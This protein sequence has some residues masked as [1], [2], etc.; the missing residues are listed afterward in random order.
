M[1]LMTSPTRYGSIARALHWS[2]AVLFLA[3][4]LAGDGAG[5]A[6][7]HGA[8]GAVSWV[9]GFHAGAGLSLIGLLVLRVLWRAVDPA[10]AGNADAPAWEAKAAHWAHRA[11]YA[12]MAAMPLSGVAVALTARQPMPVLGLGWMSIDAIPAVLSSPTLNKVLEEAHEAVSSI[13]VA[14]VAL[15][16]AATAWHALVRRDAVAQRMVPFIKG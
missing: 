15:H 9:A 6:L 14:V 1:T 2:M 11:L 13:L 4:Y 12:L 16:V 7:E 10:P 5:D 8:P 3:A